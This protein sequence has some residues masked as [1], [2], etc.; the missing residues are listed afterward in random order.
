MTIGRQRT[1]IAPIAPDA[2]G[3][4]RKNGCPNTPHVV[5]IEPE[6]LLG[7]LAPVG[8]ITRSVDWASPD[9]AW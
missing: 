1:T 9:A 3:M 4:P 7:P 6:I 5:G 2:P 8:K